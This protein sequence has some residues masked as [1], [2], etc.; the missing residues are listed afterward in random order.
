TNGSAVF[1]NQV[2]QAFD[3][4]N[5]QDYSLN[6]SNSGVV[7]G[8]TASGTTLGLNNPVLSGLA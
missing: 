2:N 5:T 3:N 4:T 1:S 7:N 6:K 8:N